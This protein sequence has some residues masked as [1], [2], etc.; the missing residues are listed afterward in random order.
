MR[1]LRRKLLIST[2]ATLVLLSGAAGRARADSVVASE[3]FEGPGLPP[4]WTLTG[5]LDGMSVT[6]SGGVSDAVPG[7]SPTQ[8]SQFAWIDDDPGFAAFGISQSAL[9]SPTFNITA[10]ETISA[11]VNF[12]AVDI[13][14]FADFANVFL[15]SSNSVVATLFSAQAGCG[16]GTLSPDMHPPSPGVTLSPST[17]D[18]QGNVVGPLDGSVYGP[19]RGPGDGC[20]Q[21]GL[22]MHPLGGSMGWVMTSYTPSPGTYQLFFEVDNALDTIGPSALA[23]DNVRITTPEPE[24]FAL[25]LISLIGMFA[26]RGLRKP[27]YASGSRIL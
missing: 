6:G 24:T 7:L 1:Q 8:G 4:G 11:D 15:M 21:L 12:M 19:L 16:N 10:G 20:A 26:L 13:P 25:L 23:I 3:G 27:R 17:V 22:P 9:E 18:F 2:I 14:G 5:S